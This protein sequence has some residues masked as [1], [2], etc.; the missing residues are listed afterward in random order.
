QKPHDRTNGRIY[1]IVYKDSKQSPVDVAKMTDADLVKAQT[2][3]N[4]W[5]VRHA[6]RVL[7]ER[8]PKP[9]VHQALLALLHDKSLDVPQRLRALWALHVTK[10]L[11][12]KLAIE[13]F[14]GDQPWLKAWMIQFG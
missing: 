6:R 11:N 14:R 10:G 9:E 12:E 4:E 7:Q 8:G 13:L 3:K 2:S 1:K 5:L